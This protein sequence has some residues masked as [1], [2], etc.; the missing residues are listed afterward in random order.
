MQTMQTK[1]MLM[2]ADAPSADARVFD[3]ARVIQSDAPAITRR[4]SIS[5]RQ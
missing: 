4:R 5:N 1:P 2:P 3:R